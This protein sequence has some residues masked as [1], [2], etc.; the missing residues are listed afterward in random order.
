MSTGRSLGSCPHCE[1]DVPPGRLLIEYETK[2]GQDLFAECPDCGVV[3][4]PV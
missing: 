3:V 1:A 4:T 2:S